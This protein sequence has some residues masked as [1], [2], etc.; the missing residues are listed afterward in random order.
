MNPGE[1]DH[2][3]EARDQLGLDCET[4]LFPLAS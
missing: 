1:H 2:G 3:A 4:H